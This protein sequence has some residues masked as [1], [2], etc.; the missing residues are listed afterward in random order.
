[1]IIRRYLCCL[2]FGIAFFSSSSYA[3]TPQ[4]QA[5]TWVFSQQND[6]GSW[7]KG[8]KKFITTYNV[9][10]MLKQNGLGYGDAYSRGLAYALN[11][12]VTSIEYRAKKMLLS[13]V[14]NDA[15]IKS[16]INE[17]QL[18]E[19]LG[20]RSIGKPGWG[21]YPNDE[22]NYFDSALVL[23]M[24]AS[25]KL[26]HGLNLN[27]FEQAKIDKLIIYIR[28][29]EANGLWANRKVGDPILYKD[30][31]NT[32]LELSRALILSRAAGLSNKT[33]NMN[34]TVQWMAE[35]I[36]T[37]GSVK[38]G[39]T[40]EERLANTARLASWN[41]DLED[42]YQLAGIANFFTADK[43]SRINSYLSQAVS[44][45]SIRN[46]LLMTTYMLSSS[47]FSILDSDKD[48]LPNYV[49][50]ALG[51]NPNLAESVATNS[52]DTL[53][54]SDVMLRNYNYSFLLSGLAG[55]ELEL[56]SALPKGL[57]LSGNKIAGRPTVEGVSVV[58]IKASKRNKLIGIVTVVLEVIDKSNN[59]VDRDQD[60]IKDSWELVNGWSPLSQSDGQM[61]FLEAK[62]KDSDGDGLNDYFELE[63]GLNYLSDIETKIDTDGDGINDAAEYIAGWDPYK[64]DTDGDGLPDKWEQQYGLN[65]S[66]ANDAGYDFDVDGLNN[67][68]EYNA[69]THPRNPD[70]DGDKVTDGA[71]M[72]KNLN[73]KSKKDTDK[74]GMSDDWETYYG[75]NKDSSNDKSLDKDSDGLSNYLE[76]AVNSNP[77][78]VDTDKDNMSD[79]DEYNIGRIPTLNEPAILIPILSVL[80]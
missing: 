40:L 19:Q 27:A 65:P 32:T 52:I 80:N 77:L 6:D 79:G 16:L 49:E 28:K 56:V 46:D 24:L 51:R 43:K 29:S 12:S 5:L 41:V 42:S 47:S 67:K 60:G 25:Y 36:N 4:E 8:N 23:T 3:A 64:S 10:S 55:Y 66:D 17:M 34:T 38:S 33:E 44:S 30:D 20:G 74:D 68:Q 31:F 58:H 26:R 71:E 50:T 15:A 72:A 2:L 62:Q 59:T 75:L 21:S 9:L 45:G 48:G 7:G 39:M 22:S 57:S 63:N 73:P 13:G 14:K 37:D 35:S 54:Y 11:K 61:A 78:D 76:Y 18:T 70:T 69:K 1:M 53:N